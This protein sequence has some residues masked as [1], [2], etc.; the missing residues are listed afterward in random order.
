MDINEC[1]HKNS[2]GKIKLE[3]KIHKITK[4]VSYSDDLLV[5]FEKGTLNSNH[6]HPWNKTWTVSNG[7][8]NIPFVVTDNDIKKKM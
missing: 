2:L 6:D 3:G 4:L 7:T 8:V 1:L 5:Y